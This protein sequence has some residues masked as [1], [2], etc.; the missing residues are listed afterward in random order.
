MTEVT[1][2]DRILEIAT[3]VLAARSGD[4]MDPMEEEVERSLRYAALLLSKWEE[5]YPA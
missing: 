2:R 1:R 3:R 4:P 5:E